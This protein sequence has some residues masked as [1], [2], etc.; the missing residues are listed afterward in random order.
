MSTV[1]L[2]GTMVLSACNVTTE[3]EATTGNTNNDQSSILGA[4]ADEK[5]KYLTGSAD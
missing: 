5:I 4:A 3:D 2:L 1:V